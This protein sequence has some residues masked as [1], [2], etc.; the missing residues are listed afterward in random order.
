MKKFLLAAAAV[1][2][3][4]FFTTSAQASHGCNSGFGY[5][6]HG[7]GHRGHTSF[8]HGHRGHGHGGYGYYAPRRV[9]VY[10]YGYYGGRRH[11]HHRPGGLHIGGR[12]FRL[13]IRF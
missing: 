6:G 8:Y 2:A 1:C 9:R 13:G 4:A 11:H 5:G 7:H 3:L 12:N 10:D